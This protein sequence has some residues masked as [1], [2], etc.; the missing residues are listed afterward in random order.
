MRTWFAHIRTEKQLKEKYRELAKL[1]HSDT[2]GSDSVMSEINA[3]RDQLLLKF[4]E[5]KRKRQFS[6]EQKKHSTNYEKT[7]HTNGEYNA[8]QAQDDTKYKQKE[9]GLKRTQSGK[10]EKNPFFT[11]DEKETMLDL[12]ISALNVVFQAGKRKILG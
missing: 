12:G 9:R 1:H 4:A 6:A 10:N 11:R 2:G 8:K 5:A 3:E 7:T